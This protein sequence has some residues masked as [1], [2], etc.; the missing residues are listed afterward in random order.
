MQ[1]FQLLH[2]QTGN[3]LAALRSVAAGAVARQEGQGQ[4]LPYKLCAINYDVMY[5][6]MKIILMVPI[7]RADTS[8]CFLSEC[9]S[10]LLILLLFCLLFIFPF[11]L[12]LTLVLILLTFVSHFVPPFYVV[13]HL[14]DASAILRRAL[15]FLRCLARQLHIVPLF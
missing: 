15:L 4:A 7:R 6:Y 9:C 1:R 13:P 2:N 3:P 11:L 14:V 5:N 8:S 12:F 10:C